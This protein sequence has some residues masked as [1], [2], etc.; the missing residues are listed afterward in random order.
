[1]SCVLDASALLAY[2]HG[3]PGADEVS[4]ALANTAVIGAANLAEALSKLADLG[5]RPSEFAERLRARG[6]LDVLLLVEPVSSEDGVAIAELRHAGHR[7][8]SL[9]DRA[10]LAL[11]ARLGLPVVTADRAWADLRLEVA[12]SLIR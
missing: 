10:C 11:A 4:D 6:V 9:G 3:E 5:H 8:L 1:L 2:L 7:A 12:V